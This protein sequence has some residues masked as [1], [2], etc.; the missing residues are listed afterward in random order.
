M[1]SYTYLDKAGVGFDCDGM[2]ADLKAMPPNSALL[3]HACAHNP[4]GV[5]PTHEQWRQIC[6]TLKARPDLAIFFDSA[7]QGF[8]SGDAEKDAYA[9]RLFV[10]EG[11][12]FALAQ[13]FAKNFGLYGERV[14]VLSMVCNE[15]EEASRVLSQLKIVVRAMYSNPP[16][17]GAR[18]VAEVLGDPTLEAQWRAECKQM[19]DRIIEMREAL[20]SA[21]VKAGSTKDWGHIT[22]Q[23]GMFCYSGLK[24]DQ[25]DKLRSD[26][27]IYI[28]K[29][30]RIS[31]AGI[32][33]SNVDYVAAAMH[34]VSK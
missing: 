33:T 22:S 17:H 31:M 24:P 11:V 7:Y 2:L 25:V 19:A 15:A 10:S 30:G 16:V 32:T 14:G 13:S 20:Q 27:N 6:A 5:D 26:Y 8:A 28:T 3:L 18:I 29:D 34:E 4:T 12:P 9:M 23:I 21:I 1:K